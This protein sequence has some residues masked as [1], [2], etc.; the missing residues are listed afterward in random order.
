MAVRCIGQRAHELLSI[1]YL[2]GIQL[3]GQ[4]GLVDGQGGFVVRD[5]IVAGAAADGRRA[6]YDFVC[7]SALVGL[8]SCQLNARQSVCALQARH[9][10]IGVE[11]TRVAARR[12]LCCAVIL[13][14]LRYGCYGQ[15]LLRD[16]QVGLGVADLV[17][18]GVVADGGRT[19]YYLIL[20][21]AHIAL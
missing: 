2:R 3:D 11:A 6:R 1:V 10:H 20:V 8:A 5:L 12:S 19:R 17:V 14:G 4:D 16:R 13:V 7:I 18:A 15:S 21:D 9:R